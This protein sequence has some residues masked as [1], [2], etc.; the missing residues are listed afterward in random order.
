MKR[1]STAVDAAD[2]SD[3]PDPRPGPRAKRPG[4][5]RLALLLVLALGLVAGAVGFG[6]AC[7]RPLDLNT[8]GPMAPGGVVDRL[9]V[10]ERMTYS[11]HAL[12]GSTLGLCGCNGGAVGLQWLKAAWH[13]ES[14]AEEEQAAVGLRRAAALAGGPRALEQ[15]VCSY[16]PEEIKA[17]QERAL[18]LAGLSCPA[19][20]TE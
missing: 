16:F 10:V 7:A 20:V 13:A 8:V 9:L 4:R 19:R 15:Q 11:A 1:P 17:S 14:P 12:V 3:D 5:L 6:V 2:L 18:R